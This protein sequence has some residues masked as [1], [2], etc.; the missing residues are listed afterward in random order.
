MKCWKCNAE[1]PESPLGT[2]G[3]LSFRA[4]CERCSAWL[5]CCKNCKNYK[6]GLPNDCLI[7]GT[8]LISDRE[9]SNFCEDFQ[10]LGIGPQKFGDPKKVADKLFKDGDEPPSR[11]KGFN[12]LFDGET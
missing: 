9:A 10:Q 4:L 8:D 12:T 5:H 1:Q 11:A 6:Q 3:K 7:P 2:L